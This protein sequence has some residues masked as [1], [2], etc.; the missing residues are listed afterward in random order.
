MEIEQFL[1]EGVYNSHLVQLTE[2]FRADQKLKH[3][4]KDIVQML[5]NTDRLG[6]STTSLGSL[7]QGLTPLS[8]EMLPNVQSKL[9]L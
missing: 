5:F 6:L 4:I 8:K 1:M 9:P 7:F 3:V 2:L